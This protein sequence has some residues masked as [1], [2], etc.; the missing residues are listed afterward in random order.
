VDNR[1]LRIK[2]DGLT[3]SFTSMDFQGRPKC[4][5]GN[6]YQIKPGRL[7]EGTLNTIFKQIFMMT[8]LPTMDNLPIDT[9]KRLAV[10][11][12]EPY[13]GKK[14]Q[15]CKFRQQYMLYLFMPQ[16]QD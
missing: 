4:Y 13:N 11:T 5:I 9:N 7:T 3:G 10:A 8:Q 12:P 6:H 15:F 2:R 16:T 14:D 1:H